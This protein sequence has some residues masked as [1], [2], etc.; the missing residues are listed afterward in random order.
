MIDRRGVL[1]SAEL[2]FVLASLR[3]DDD[4]KYA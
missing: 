2:K 3:G 1:E 4:A